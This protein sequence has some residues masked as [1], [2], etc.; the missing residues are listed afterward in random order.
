LLTRDG[1]DPWVQTAALSSAAG[2]ATDLLHA[3][4]KGEDFVKTAHAAAVLTR[5]ATVIGAQADDAALARV[6][7]VLGEQPDSAAWPVAVLDGLGQ[8]L[9][10]S[11]RSLRKLWDQPP[12]ALADAV[13]RVLPLFRRAAA[14]AADPK[15]EEAERATA[16]RRLGYGP[17]DVA[18]D[19]LAAALGPQ[20]PPE[21]QA[22]AVRALAAQDHP[23]VAELLLAR[24]DGYGPAVRRE[25]VE[26]LCAR[27]ARLA[28]LL[29][30]IE[31]KTVSP[32]QL[33]AARRAQLLRHP[34]AA[35]RKQA[36]AL[37][38]NVGSPD[39]RKVVEDYRP[40]LDL[41]AD[42]ARGKTV[43]QKNCVTCH[44]LGDEGHDVGPDLRAVLGTKTPE[45][46]LVDILDP[47]REVDP[48]YVN[49]QVTTTGGRV[50]TGLLAVETPAS[51]TLRRADQAED[52]ILRSQ[53]E[54]M[55]AT[56]QSLMP[57]ELEKQ[58]SK[59]DLADLIAYLR[60]QAAPR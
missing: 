8:G 25:A 45:A 38:A 50:V 1:A 44:K 5:L 49:Y 16:L 47:N 7:R 40:A 33:E 53:I 21:L 18:A 28:K 12:P 17:F 30:A 36:E 2:N 15:R 11:K 52:T 60:S 48:R 3:L 22:A 9:Q 51:V 43:F 54:S 55:Q 58:L 19:A 56:A 14:I 57:E 59:Q 24:W 32:S 29:D 27:S 6:F 31:A 10:N 37:L 4:T 41:P 13:K 46:L 34:N 23:R 42:T 35:L 20:N 39:R 26:A